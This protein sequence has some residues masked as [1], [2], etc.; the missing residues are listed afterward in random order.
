MHHDVVSYVYIVEWITLA[1][2][3][4]ILETLAMASL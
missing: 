2:F 1:D 3:L 4:S